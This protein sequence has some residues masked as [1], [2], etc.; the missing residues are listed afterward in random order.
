M[1]STTERRHG[2]NARIPCAIPVELRHDAER[3]G[4]EAAA[5]D[6]S[7]GGL[8]LRASN[9]PEV[10]ATLH[11]EFETL[12]GGTRV[13]GR[14]EVVWAKLSGERSGEF[15]L[16]FTDIE[17]QAQALIGEMIAERVALGQN[18]PREPR[19]A[20]LEFEHVESPITAKLTR[21][22]GRDV[23]FEQPLGVL[24]LGSG[25]I[26]HSD[27]NLG[28]GNLLRVDL[29]MD[30]GTPM[31]A[32]TVRFS[33]PQ[34]EYGEYD[35]DEPDTGTR[36]KSAEPDLAAPSFRSDPEV[37]TVPDLAAPL[38]V[39]E[40]PAPHPMAAGEDEFEGE[41]AEDTEQD[42]VP[43]HAHPAR[44]TL[45]PGGNETGTPLPY[46]APIA[47]RST[48]AAASQADAVRGRPA[49]EFA[50]PHDYE[51]EPE[52][53]S[54]REYEAIELEGTE[55]ETPPG[56]YQAPQQSTSSGEHRRNLDEDDEDGFDSVSESARHSALV[57][58]LRIFAAIKQAGQPAI[59]A[60]QRLRDRGTRAIAPY[61]HRRPL[62][63]TALT[64][65][66][67]GVGLVSATK[68]RRSAGVPMAEPMPKWSRGMGRLTLLAALMAGAGMLLV[69]SL[70]PS[71][72]T[73]EIELHRSVEAEPP[74]DDETS[75]HAAMDGELGSAAESGME[76]K[77]AAHNSAPRPTGKASGKI[78]LVN[79]PVTTSDK[80]DKAGRGSITFGHKNVPNAKRFLLRT[81]APVT[82]LQGKTEP[83]GFSVSISGT[84][85]IDRA[86]PIADTTKSVARSRILNRGNSAELT[87][88]FVE[89]KSPAYRV[90]A[91]PAGLEVL[92][93]P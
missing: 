18:G 64:N 70:T 91:Q 27:K 66:L 50:T 26:A 15:G 52:E 86:A 72:A 67:R 56:G 79:A 30:G 62:R 28:H 65:T 39:F 93:S 19:M 58:F 11:C 23:V 87:I 3:P 43:Q 60:A 38:G 2:D 32:L 41:A 61:L 90:I 76:P 40:D 83:N 6:L 17:P 55:H 16:R 71:A 8:S 78:S 53:H 9:L 34:E 37:D 84:R 45:L 77:A 33:E 89:G 10:G 74:V 59:A 7:A 68:T 5:V 88:Q 49:H 31:L 22:A 63:R 21:A 48:L 47:A 13:S 24:A 12:P 42:A 75:I 73:E 36:P 44:T 82:T 25:V 14:G 92:I 35:W 81:T 46:R 1:I 20:T 54:V 29:R 4:F 57:R 51:V 80:A 85:A 69:Y